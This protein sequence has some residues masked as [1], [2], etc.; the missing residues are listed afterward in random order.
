MVSDLRLTLIEKRNPGHG[1]PDL[2]SVLSKQLETKLPGVVKTGQS[3]AICVGSRGISKLPDIVAAAVNSVKSEN[4]EPFIVPCMGSHGGATAEGQ[5]SILRDLGVSEESMGCPVRSGMEVTRIGQTRFGTDVVVDAL[6][7]EAD[8]IIPINRIKPHTD[9]FGSIQSGVIKMLAI[10]LGNHTGAQNYHTAFS[11]H[12]FTRVVKAVSGIVLQKLSIPFGIGIVENESHEIQHLELINSRHLIQAERRLLRIA[13][14]SM[15]QLPN[16]PYDLLI[17]DQ[18][19]K[20]ISGSG[21]DT[22]IIGM[23]QGLI[24]RTIESRTPSPLIYVRGLTGESHGNA[25]GI[26]LAS[27]IH[28]RMI[29]QVDWPATYTNC[30]T[31]GSPKGAAM[32]IPFS[33][34]EEALNQLI[35]ILG[36]PVDE[37]RIIRIRDTLNLSRL[38]VSGVILDQI[39]KG[40]TYKIPG[41]PGSVAFNKSGNLI[42]DLTPDIR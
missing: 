41:D 27:A 25:V 38:Y 21:M 17:V 4:C 6:A 2:I 37:L 9:F 29:D 1:D 14:K 32:P 12:G 5:I 22:N 16:V 3:I 42:P 20:D 23:K 34:D 30:L 11:E 19:G 7:A 8:H 13:T 33:S 10:G 15:A 31:S 24:R 40:N 18:I 39:S 28:R 36:K 26:G 35:Q